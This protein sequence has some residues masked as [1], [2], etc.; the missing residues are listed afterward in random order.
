MIIYRNIYLIITIALS[1]FCTNSLAACVVNG[2]NGELCT[3]ADENVFSTCLWKAE[4]MCY[5][6]YGIC[7]ED[8]KGECN[9]RQTNQLL[10]C[11]KNA[12]DAVEA[13]DISGD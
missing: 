12:I 4:Y 11:I 7:E 1:I 10:T 6:D 5:K 3:S 9:W 2:C 13:A 8:T